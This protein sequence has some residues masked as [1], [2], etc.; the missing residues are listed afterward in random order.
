MEE[1]SLREYLGKLADDLELAPRE[2]KSDGSQ[3]IRVSETWVKLN[4][5]ILREFV[6]LMDA[7]D[8]EV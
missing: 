4:T 8:E 7:G 3:H 5:D 6:G 2:E 1:V